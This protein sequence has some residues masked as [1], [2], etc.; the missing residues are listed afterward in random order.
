LDL[1]E[2]M[3]DGYIGKCSTMRLL[4]YRPP[5]ANSCSPNESILGTVL[6]VRDNGVYH[7]DSGEKGER[8]GATRGWGDAGFYGNAN[9]KRNWSY[10]S[11]SPLHQARSSLYCPKP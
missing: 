9:R 2:Q 10:M 4:R 7:L 3:R 5:I 1:L 8:M 6:G 11:P